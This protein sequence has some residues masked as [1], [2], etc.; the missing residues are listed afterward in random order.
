MSRICIVYSTTDGHTLEIC[1]RIQQVLEQAGQLSGLDRAVAV[2]P[3]P[4]T[5]CC[6]D[7]ALRSTG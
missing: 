5:G 3:F 6:G 1:E 2:E 4:E 7:L